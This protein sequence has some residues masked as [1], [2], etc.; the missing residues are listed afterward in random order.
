V[1][2]ELA[3][4]VGGSVRWFGGV[5]PA[6]LPEMEE[7]VFE[8]YL[9]GLSEAGWRGDRRT[10]RLGYLLTSSMM[11]API[12]VG[13]LGHPSDNT[14]A[15]VEASF[16]RPLEEVIWRWSEVN[17]HIVALAAEARSLM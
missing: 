17:Q 5:Q 2:G 6:Q 1:G 14:R 12:W 13:S 10:V 7:A 9:Q 15:W 8:S 16:R 4:L 11:F 3:S